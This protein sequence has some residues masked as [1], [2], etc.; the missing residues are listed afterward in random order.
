MKKKFTL[1]LVSLIT[2]S[3][4]AQY[5]FTLVKNSDY[6]YTVSAVSGFDSGTDQPNM[7]SFGFTIMLPSGASID[8]STLDFKYLS[9]GEFT[10]TDDAA[11]GA[12][13][14]SEDRDAI[15]ITSS[16][17]SGVFS[18]H[19]SAVTLDLLTFDVLGDP[20]SGKVE[21]LS[22][23]ETPADAVG[24]AF[25]SYINIDSSGGTMNV[26]D[27]YTGQSGDTEFIFNSLSN[28]TFNA[29]SFEMHPN[30]TT[31]TFVIALSQDI[32]DVEVAIWD[33]RGRQVSGV[34]TQQTNN[35]INIEASHL[36]AGVY[37]VE[38]IKGQKSLQKRL[39]IK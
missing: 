14:P 13:D 7:E 17:G 27:Q 36:E 6:Q 35:T 19:L 3:S 8:Q 21:L 23:D 22:N 5:S 10:V 39:V 31:G 9:L 32:G 28:P 16:S 15:L 4:F 12:L 1:L 20:T 29:T 34:R 33:L 38:V 25:D 18:A 2:I 11:L 26:T 30:P 24:G 37:M